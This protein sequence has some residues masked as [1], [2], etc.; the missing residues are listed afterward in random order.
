MDEIVFNVVGSKAQLF[1]WPE[2]GL[3]L[4]VPEGTLDRTETCPVAITT[5]I[6]GKFKFP[7]GFQLISALYAISPRGKFKKNVKIIF[8]HCFLI[9]RKDQIS[10]LHFIKAHPIAGP[11]I[12]YIF[13]TVKG[14]IFTEGSQ[15]C[16]LSLSNFSIYGAA[17]LSNGNENPG[18]DDEENENENN[19]NAEMLENNTTHEEDS[20]TDDDESGGEEEVHDPNDNGYLDHNTHQENTTDHQLLETTS[21]SECAEQAERTME[22]KTEQNLDTKKEK[23][24]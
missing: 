21:S 23:G 12:P 24:K 16:E 7:E 1:E 2:C 10:R 15:D 14:G 13:E 5:L 6:S 4:Y 11:S 8:E 3:S 18:D 17:V 20:E 19:G 9:E 22:E